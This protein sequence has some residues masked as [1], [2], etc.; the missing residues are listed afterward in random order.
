L[1]QVTADRALEDMHAL[2]VTVRNTERVVALSASRLDMERSEREPSSVILEAAAAL[3]R[4]NR[5]TGERGSVIPD[6]IALTRDAFIPARD[7]ANCFRRELPLSEP[8]W[9]D[10]IATRAFG[11]PAR[12]RGLP[13]LNLER[14]EQ[15]I[16][17][18]GAGPMDGMIGGLAAQL[19]MPGLSLGYPISASGIGQLLSC[20]HA[21]L[22]E[23]LLRFEEPAA[24]PPQREI[25]QPYYGLFFHDVAAKFYTINGPAFCA[26]KGNLADWFKVAEQLVEGAF[27]EFLKQYPLVGAGVKAQQRRRLSS[28]LRELLRYDWDRLKNAGLVTEKP[29]GYPKAV[30]L[31]IGTKVLHLR[32]RIDRIE[33]SGQKTV[34]RDLKTARAHPRIGKE[35]NPDPGLDVQIALYGLITEILADEWKLP[36]RVETGYAYFGRPSGERVFGPDFQTLLKPAAAR[37]LE[38]AA[39]LLAQKQFPRTPNSKDCDY[40]CFRPVCG[41]AVYA[42][43]SV[44]LA[45]SSG[46]LADFAALKI[47]QTQK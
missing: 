25:G 32:G 34:V 39:S 12:W 29:F 1:L 15:L 11:L 28:D 37:W 20:P 40:C 19:P 35:A 46:P 43:A 30:P 31:P 4:P 9:Q 41:D 45:N 26:H 33:I 24:P 47:A 23:R 27:Q 38:I 3:S 8:A 44:L 22:L 14:I 7:V 5:L 6:R 21:F 2:D 18:V 42:R 17:D 36:K 10:G 16:D 13:V